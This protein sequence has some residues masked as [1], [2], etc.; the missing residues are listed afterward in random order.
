MIQEHN[1]KTTNLFPGLVEIRGCTAT[2][3]PPRPNVEL[4]AG[5][6]DGG[7]S[8]GIAFSDD[9]PPYHVVDNVH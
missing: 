4:R 9:L 2:D 3:L 5:E 7:L 6:Y 1:N 8:H